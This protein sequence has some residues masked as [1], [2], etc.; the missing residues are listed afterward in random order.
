MCTYVFSYTFNGLYSQRYA[1]ISSVI[2]IVLLDSYQ[3]KAHEFYHQCDD[4]TEYGINKATLEYMIRINKL[5][6]DGLC[7]TCRSFELSQNALMLPTRIQILDSYP[8]S[9]KIVE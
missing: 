1:A 3:N 8:V 5:P 4:W 6:G 2:L 7:L 9:T